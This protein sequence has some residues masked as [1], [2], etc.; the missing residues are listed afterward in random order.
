MTE[1]HDFNQSKAAGD[2]G[3]QFLDRLFEQRGNKVEP[4]TK[5]EQR[6]D[7]I[8]RKITNPNNGKTVIVEYKTDMKAKQTGNVFVETF[9]NIENGTPGWIGAS[10]AEWLVTLIPDECVLITRLSKIRECYATKWVGYNHKSVPNRVGNNIYHTI[11][12]PVPIEKYI[13][14]SGATKIDIAQKDAA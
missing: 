12:F 6:D 8:D 4:V 11:G 1:I 9:S 10:K 14:E 3:E 2:E 13:T 7:K 5:Q